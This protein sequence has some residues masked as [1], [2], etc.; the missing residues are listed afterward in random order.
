MYRV[1]ILFLC[2]FSFLFSKD[3]EKKK[4]LVLQSYHATL[5]WTS[6]I[7]NGLKKSIKKYDNKIELFIEHFDYIRLGETLTPIKI[8]EIITQKY[9]NI[10]F[11]G[12]IIES[13]YAAK[14]YNNF[15]YKYNK[16]IPH[17]YAVEDL[18]ELKGKFINVS[19]NKNKNIIRT[20]DLI[21]RLHPNLEKVLFIESEDGEFSK[22]KRELLLNTGLNIEIYNDFS[23]NELYRKVQKLSPNTVI[24]Y[25]LV[26]RD[27]KNEKAVP[28]KILDDIIELSPN[29]IYSLH[30][31]LLGKGVMGGHVV[32]AEKLALT[33]V[34]ALMD[35]IDNKEFKK[36]YSISETYLNWDMLEKFNIIE[37]LIPNDVIVINKPKTLL[38]SF[39]YETIL[40]SIFIVILLL[41]LVLLVKLNLRLKLETKEKIEKQEMLNQQ[42]KNALMGE[43]INNIAHQWRQPLARINSNIAVIDLVTF[44]NEKKNL[45]DEKLINIEDQTAYMSSTIDDFSNFFSPDKKMK[46]FNLSYS[47]KKSIALLSSRLKEIHVDYIL[48]E[49]IEINSFE[50]EFSQVILA[51]VNNA[52]DNFVIKR[53]MNPI[54]E[55]NLKKEDLKIIVEISDNGGGIDDENIKKIFDAHFST[56]KEIKSTGLGL[57]ISKNI[58]ENSMN[59]E[60]EVFNNIS[61]VT[62]RISFDNISLK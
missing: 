19:S 57:Y 59:G 39:F 50:N 2:F 62:F 44:T 6:E 53:V 9:N 38:E 14:V 17:V 21:K 27:N 56:K 61:G 32:N 30:S 11:D 4:I 49:T 10:K 42:S 15:G 41:F 16:T 20:L 52:V 60:L 1:L 26:F 40:T 25:S 13:Y 8:E 31:S 12:V 43:M 22:T 33:M 23:I 37:S 36:H 47:L 24:L 7:N 51:I 28:R 55:I 48:D 29:P 5:P 35:Y 45:I 46:T 3:S 54:L 58:I 34:D 18:I